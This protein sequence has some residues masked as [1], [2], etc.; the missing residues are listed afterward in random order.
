MKRK[1]FCLILS[2]LMLIVFIQVPAGPAYADNK[3][4]SAPEVVASTIKVDKATVGRG[5]TV[6]ISMKINDESEIADAVLWI[7]AD[8]ELQD[9]GFG[10]YNKET[11]LWDFEVEPRYFGLTE[12][13][14][15]R[16]KDV[17]TNYMEY[18]NSAS[19][20]VYKDFDMDYV[21]YADLSGGNFTV[22][23]GSYSKE[24]DAPVIELNSLT[25][26]DPRPSLND[27]VYFKVKISDSSPIASTYFDYAYSSANLRTYGEYN[28]ESGY[29][30]YMVRCSN[31]GDFEP[32]RLVAEDAFGN[33]TTYID[34]DQRYTK[35]Y[36]YENVDGQPAN[37]SAANF[38][39]Q[40]GTGDVTP[41][42]LD[43]SSVRIDKKYLDREETTIVS[44]KASDDT[45]INCHDTDIWYAGLWESVATSCKYNKKTGRY[46]V[47]VSGDC[48]GTHQLYEIK[49]CDNYGNMVYYCD[50]STEIGELYGYEPE[51]GYKD[52]D[53][54]AAIFY[55]GIENEDTGTF[56]S[57][58]T[59]DDSTRLKVGKLDK[60]A[61]GYSELVQSGYN[62]KGFY[63]VKVKGACD[64]SSE[65]TKVFFDVP[66]GFKEGDELQVRHL[67]S[68][69]TVQTEEAV[70]R[71][72]KVGLD[73]TEFSP[74]MISVKKS[75]DKN[76]FTKNGLTY[77]VT[78]NKTVTFLKPSKSSITSLVIPATVSANGKKYKVTRINAKACKGFKNLKSVT[79]GKNVKYIGEYAFYN[80]KK[81]RT[82]TIKTTSLT[83]SK[84]GKYA[85]KGISKK[86]K[87]VLPSKKSKAYKKLL[88]NRGLGK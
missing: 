31:Y 5:G 18:Y 78:G 57:N 26:S 13:Q 14:C 21:K 38:T 49:L 17:Y 59:M 46:E 51:Q 58:S 34:K 20:R 79:I 72:G 70:V 67:L 55:V 33:M 65:R 32:L 11:G 75:K 69:G 85:F 45:G 3:D 42:T 41:P 47:M 10:S 80:C 16:V 44:F 84:V 25:V 53:L 62:V 76:L 24:S 63:E 77:Q 19:G 56:V 83:S 8:G 66:P 88:K 1:I 74:F 73:V 82:L 29:Y 28:S 48:Y 71:S 37:L 6:T 39:V 22:S 68:D 87:L 7:V 40:G 60:K 86:A 54:S 4:K 30:E 9:Y 2:F 35:E 27:E 43:V 64:M 52:V 23:R 15:I 36:G 81:V 50:M 61:D 12:I